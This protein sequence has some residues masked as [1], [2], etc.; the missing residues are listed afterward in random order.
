[1][2]CSNCGNKLDVG[3]TFCKSCSHPLE[4]VSPTPTN[5]GLPVTGD[6]SMLTTEQYQKQMQEADR[7]REIA[8]ASATPNTAHNPYVNPYNQAHNPYAQSSDNPFEERTYIPPVQPSEAMGMAQQSPPPPPPHMAGSQYP[9]SPPPPPPNPYLNPYSSN[10]FSEFN[11]KST[12][13]GKNYILVPAILILIWGG[14]SFLS[15]AFELAI[16]DTWLNDFG[17]ESARNRWI[18]HHANE[19]IFGAVGITFGIL[20]LIYH[21]SIEKGKLLMSLA[22][23]YIA[24][25]VVNYVIY[26]AVDVSSLILEASDLGEFAPLASGITLVFLPA[27]LVL[28]ILYAIGAHKNKKHYENTKNL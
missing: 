8:A 26:F 21:K 12:V 3:A 9:T 19:T 14:I 13:P 23:G 4:Q 20:G 7:E 5:A 10:P 25:T 24:A 6:D 28:P 1:M 11:Q 16:I 18:I 15:N 22:F 17:G 27:L 2:F